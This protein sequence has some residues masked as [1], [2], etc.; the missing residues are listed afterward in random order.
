MVDTPRRR[1]LIIDTD[2]GIDDA[3]ALLIALRDPNVDVLAI[4]CSHGNVSLP[5]V[6]GNVCAIVELAEAPL[7]L[8]VYSGADRPLMGAADAD[9]SEWHGKDG[10]GGTGFGEKATRLHLKLGQH[11]TSAIIDIALSEFDTT[12]VPVDIVTL[13]PL[14]NL[15]LA[16]RLCPRLATS[17]GSV[18]VMGGTSTARGNT[19]MTSEYNILQDP[20]A[21][22]IVFAT[23]PHIVLVSWDLTLKY[24]LP[25]SFIEEQYL[26]GRTPRS[27]WM[28]S[29]SRHLIVACD[30]WYH[31]VGL[32]IPDPLCVAI[33]VQPSLVIAS[34]K[35]S[36]FVE[37]G[38]K[39]ARGMTV[40]D[41]DNMSG[42]PCNVEIVEDINMD[43][44]KSM[45]AHSVE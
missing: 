22:A 19:T 4:T 6:E 30:K 20:E 24:T 33:A 14:T 15:A 16:V 45:L 8:P 37:L 36:V 9:A 23:F 35:V 29:V 44:V 27:R 38:G 5:F 7:T 34:R 11:A 13:G 10:L 32:Y 40:V 41:W 42:K 39:Y 28:A 21:A 1:K 17:V 3:Q 2:A 31:T 26:H 12:G 18:Y 25:K 43:M